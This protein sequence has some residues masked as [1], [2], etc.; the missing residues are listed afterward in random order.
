MSFDLSVRRGF[1]DGVEQFRRRIGGFASPRRPELPRKLAFRRTA[2]KHIDPY[3]RPA[4]PHQF[5]HQV[6]GGS[7]AREPQR[8]FPPQQRE[9]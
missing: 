6:S 4:M 9:A 7:E 3:G 2:R 5:E 8:S 1:D